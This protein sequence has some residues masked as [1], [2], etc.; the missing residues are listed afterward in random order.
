LGRSS[1]ASSRYLEGY[2]LDL[3]EALAG[4]QAVVEEQT[5]DRARIRLN[6]TVAGQPIE[7]RSTSSAAKGA[8]T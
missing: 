1:P 3:D 4:V 6:Y 2:G 7:A 8:G 5:G